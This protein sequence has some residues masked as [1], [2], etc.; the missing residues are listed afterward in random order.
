M[1]FQVW[2]FSFASFKITSC[3]LSALNQTYL[4]R[5]LR[6][7]WPICDLHKCWIYLHKL[8]LWRLFAHLYRKK[9]IIRQKVGLHKASNQASH[10]FLDSRINKKVLVRSMFRQSI[11]DLHYLLIFRV[12]IPQPILQLIQFSATVYH[13]LFRLWCF[14]IRV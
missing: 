10:I 14:F 4:I 8:F 6:V 11:K 3:L 12:H 7:E 5:K 13:T 9:I 1:L 2:Y